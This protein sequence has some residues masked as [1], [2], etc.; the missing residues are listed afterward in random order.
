MSTK[1][2]E[3]KYLLVS[4]TLKKAFDSIWHEGLFF[5]ILQSGIGGKVYDL[6]KC[7]YKHNQ[8]AV[9]INN[10]RTEY[11]TQGRGVKQGCCISP[12]LFNLYINELADQLD[13]SAAPGLTLLDTEIKYLLYAD[14][15]ILLS[16][17]RDGLQHN[18]SI[19]EQYCHNWALEVNFKKT[20]IMIFQKKARC[21][22]TK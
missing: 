18:L 20:Q 15:L 12:A 1:K 2:R 22:E 13:R 5:K 19:L 7:M 4:S 11:F 14:Y 21:L 6:I 3:G 10:Q 8:C 17:T 9:K 16:P